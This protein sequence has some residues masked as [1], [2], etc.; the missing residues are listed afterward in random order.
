MLLTQFVQQPTSNPQSQQLPMNP[1]RHTAHAAH[2][3]GTHGNVPLLSLSITGRLRTYAY[4]FT[5]PSIPIGSLVK[6]LPVAGSK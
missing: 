5:P 6:N 4:R 2:N 3:A 1:A